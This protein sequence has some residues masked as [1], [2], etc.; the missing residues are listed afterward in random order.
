MLCMRMEQHTHVHWLHVQEKLK[1]HTQWA[2]KA[3]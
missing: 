3:Q 1:E 2:L